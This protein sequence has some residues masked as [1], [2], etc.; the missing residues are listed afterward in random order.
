MARDYTISAGRVMSLDGDEIGRLEEDG[1]I[2]WFMQV[3][4]RPDQARP[5]PVTATKTDAGGSVILD[6]DK[7]RSGM[8]HPSGN[9]DSASIQ[10]FIADMAASGLPA[11]LGAGDFI[12]GTPMEWQSRAKIGKWGGQGI[13]LTVTGQGPG[14][15][16]LLDAT[17]GSAPMLWI[18]AAPANDIAKRNYMTDISR[19][20]IV[21]APGGVEVSPGNVSGEAIRATPKVQN[22]EVLHTPKFRDLFFDG[23][24]HCLTLSDSTLCTLDRVWFA[25]F[26]TAVRMGFNIDLLKIRQCMFGSEQFGSTYR[27]NAT[28]VL[29]GFNDGLSLINSGANCVE[30]EQTWFMK[31]G[32][33]WH[34]ATMSA[35]RAVRFKESYFE[36]VRQYYYADASNL[37]ASAP[38]AVIFDHCHFSHTAS[39]DDPAYPKIDFGTSANSPLHRLAINDCSSDE[40]PANALVAIQNN[41]GSIT[42]ERNRIVPSA[43]YGHIRSRAFGWNNQA[44]TLPTEG[45]GSYRFVGGGGLNLTNGSDPI[46]FNHSPSAGGTVMIDQLTGNFHVVTLPN[47]NIT[48]TT[49]SQNPSGYDVGTKMT[50]HLRAPASVTAERTI[51]FGAGLGDGSTTLITMATADA[52]KRRRLEIECVDQSNNRWVISDSG[53]RSTAF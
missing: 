30:V 5:Q 3:N 26:E 8:L 42:W 38:F 50:V 10:Q 15:T 22:Y 18:T 28:A 47:G 39:N 23:F 19:M 29:T 25:E 27:N 46:L 4:T 37:S 53:W 1:S 13:G 32:L 11:V 14:N 17:D 12:V 40:V 31:I 48:L 7:K 33:A 35:D 44:R 24:Q 34:Q 36:D 20:S 45:A 51:T 9:D 52:N 43:T 49:R 6:G 21:R 16:R 2:T 41:S